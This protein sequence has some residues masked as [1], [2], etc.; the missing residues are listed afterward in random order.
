MK[1]I[2]L[3]FS[4]LLLTTNLSLAQGQPKTPYSFYPETKD[5]FEPQ[6]KHYE[7]KPGD[8][9]SE[10]FYLKNLTGESL[11]VTLDT[12]DASH[13]GKSYVYKNNEEE[14]KEFGKFA[15]LSEKEITLEPY[16]TKKIILDISIP[17]DAEKKEYLGGITYQETKEVKKGVVNIAYRY[18]MGTKLKITDNPQPIEQETVEKPLSWQNYYLL[19]SILLF[20][21]GACILV[22]KPKK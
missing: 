7:L 20:I 19:G 13:D 18:A 3:I 6:I 12:V 14:K 9:Y 21:I 4:L 16:K 5:K 15:K 1:K 17:A 22:F 8:K 11:L 10:N 2:I